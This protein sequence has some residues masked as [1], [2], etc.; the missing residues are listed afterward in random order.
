MVSS[1]DYGSKKSLS[2][3][4][5]ISNGF[6]ISETGMNS[7]LT[8]VSLYTTSYPKIDVRQDVSTIIFDPSTGFIDGKNSVARFYWQRPSQRD[9]QF[10]IQSD[11]DTKSLLSMVYAKTDFPIKNLDNSFYIYTVPTAIIDVTPDISDLSSQLSSGKDDLYDVEYSYAEYV[12]TNVNYDLST[13]TAGVDQK[14]SWVLTNRKGVCDEITNLFISLNRAAGIPAR[15]V[16]GVAYTN[17][18]IFDTHFVPHAWAEVYFPKIGWVPFD[19]TYG[20]YGYIDAG[21]IKFVES[22]DASGS[23]VKYEY[24]GN[25]INL[26]PEELKTDVIVNSFGEDQKASYY[27]TPSLY[28]T[29]VGFGS[30]DIIA[31]QLENP[32]SYY[33]VADI[34]LADTEGVSI[35][36]DN[37]EKIL[38]RTLHRKE[39][40]LKPKESK[41]VYWIIKLSDSLN[42]N[43]IYTFPIT[44]YDSYNGSL[45][46]RKLMSRIL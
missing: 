20:E 38:N 19:V 13:L 34:Y 15:F 4:V 10:A 25:N 42:K 45:S 31:V 33:Q 37:P 14:S 27:Y 23:S 36:E 29:N 43:Y 3:T 28:E 5:I 9:F 26:K 44:V 32:Q 7:Y 30:Y 6:T 22:N 12:R 8:N 35:I 2:S 1:L 40:L 21:H 17:L 41:T 39:V 16:S 11:V 46:S 18:D 24:V